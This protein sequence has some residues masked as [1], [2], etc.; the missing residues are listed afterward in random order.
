MKDKV[1]Q[2]KMFREKALKK[3]GGDMLPKYKTGDLNV[4]EKKPQGKLDSGIAS[5]REVFPNFLNVTG[6]NN[7]ADTGG[8]IL[9]APYDSK[10]AM[11]L[12]IAGQLLQAQ[13]R[14]GESIFSGVGRGVGKAITEDF[15]VI[16]K[17][18]LEDRAARAKSLKDILGTG[19]G[20][21]YATAY[22]DTEEK[23]NKPKVS[24]ATVEAN[25]G[26]YID[27]IEPKSWTLLED[28]PEIGKKKGDTY[29]TTPK[30]Y[31][32]NVVDPD[33]AIPDFL[34][35][36][37]PFGELSEKEKR[38]S[39]KAE[40][41]DEIDI[42][43]EKTSVETGVKFNAVN[44]SLDQLKF[45]IE[46]PDTKLGLAGDLVKFADN[47]RATLNNINDV[48]YGKNTAERRNAENLDNIGKNKAEELLDKRFLTEDKDGTNVQEYFISKYGEKKGNAFMDR[49]MEY[50]GKSAKHRAVFTEVLYTIAK[51]R[52]EGG[53]FSVSDIELAALSLGA[54]GGSKEQAV[55]ALEALRENFARRAYSEITS[56]R[57]IL[58]KDNYKG[59]LPDN[60]NE[61]SKQEQN[62]LME[63]LYLDQD[64]KRRS[65]YSTVFDLY[66]EY[67]KIKADQ[68]KQRKQELKEESKST[69]EAVT[70]ALEAF[71]KDNQQVP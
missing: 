53:R 46:D 52:E 30:L 6:E 2:R 39:K 8:G 29:Y 42:G 13:Q 25:P 23:E 9:G 26:R 66:N 71:E 45:L 16:Q 10:K 63:N 50:A 15:P 12:A 37:V 65:Y 22:F 61:L 60:F 31:Y 7:T 20:A 36:V 51:F 58:V 44:E 43:L 33:T 56:S 3:Y 70:E 49:I 38:K 68:L 19:E 35:K 17:L 32:E 5:I 67:E 24:L 54:T 28:I 59:S 1:L 47:T 11:V 41:S 34:S 62:V 4:G 40:A 48:L 64:P 57:G 14:P 69:Q 55:A 27:K 18:N 21:K